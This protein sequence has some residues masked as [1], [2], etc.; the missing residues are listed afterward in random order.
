MPQAHH[1]AVM[2]VHFVAFDQQQQQL[3]SALPV[4][5]ASSQSLNSSHHNQSLRNKGDHPYSGSGGGGAGGA[6]KES[7]QPQLPKARATIDYLGNNR[8]CPT[9]THLLTSS[10]IS[11][12]PNSYRLL[13]LTQPPGNFSSSVATSHHHSPPLF[14]NIY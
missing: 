11:F 3:Q 10:Y 8:T 6:S 7:D 13:P 2:N 5:D 4:G 9:V 1:A 14:P 12:R